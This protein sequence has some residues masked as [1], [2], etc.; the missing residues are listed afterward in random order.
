MLGMVYS[1]SPLVEVEDVFKRDPQRSQYWLIAWF[2]PPQA[3]H[4]CMKILIPISQFFNQAIAGDSD[5]PVLSCIEEFL[6]I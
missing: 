1:P 6:S 5:L 4:L 2:T 3:G